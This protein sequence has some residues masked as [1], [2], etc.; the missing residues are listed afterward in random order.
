MKR[1]QILALVLVSLMMVALTT[2]GC[3][4]SG[5]EQ[6]K[7]DFE[8]HAGTADTPAQTD[9]DQGTVLLDNDVCKVTV[10]GTKE[11]NWEFAIQMRCENR[12]RKK[13]LMFTVDEFCIDGYLIDPFWADEVAP[14]KKNDSDISFMPPPYEKLGI[15]A[16]DEISFLLRVYDND[17]K[18]TEDL[19]AEP[20]TIYPTGLTPDR[21]V[22]PERRTTSTEKTIVDDD[23]VTFVILDSESDSLWS[24]VLHCYL[25]NKTG[26]PITFCWSDVTV[27]GREEDPLWAKTLPGGKK[28]YA[29]VYIP[30]PDGDGT[31]DA[32]NSIGFT[33]R[34]YDPAFEIPEEKAAFE[35]QVYEP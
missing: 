20:F 5:I 2:A 23:Q 19:V 25:E 15:T 26:K 21:I 16:A 22:Y 13:T 35:N 30:R 29:N 27:D 33:L 17:E 31:T 14:G 18:Q 10:L 11:D 8:I 6:P 24:C 34:L 28:C 12:T 4:R 1:K 9:S 3:S 32:P 7:A